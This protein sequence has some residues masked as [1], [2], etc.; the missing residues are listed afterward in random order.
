MCYIYIIHIYVLYIVLTLL[1]LQIS[2]YILKRKDQ[3]TF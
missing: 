3:I 1:D 2:G